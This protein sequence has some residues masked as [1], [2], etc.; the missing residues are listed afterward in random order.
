M[1]SSTVAKKDKI[2]QVEDLTQNRS[3]NHC[4]YASEVMVYLWELPELHNY[5]ETKS[6]DGFHE[7]QAGDSVLCQ[8]SRAARRE[9]SPRAHWQPPERAQGGYRKVVTRD[10]PREHQSWCFSKVKEHN[11]AKWQIQWKAVWKCYL[12]S[13]LENLLYNLWQLIKVPHVSFL[14]NQSLRLLI[15]HQEGTSQ[16]HLVLE[17]W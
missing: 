3:Q 9:G 7:C 5:Q 11:A 14:S 6:K 17:S 13:A 4:S 2:Q 12:H 8:R 10:S 1:E 15:P 16:F